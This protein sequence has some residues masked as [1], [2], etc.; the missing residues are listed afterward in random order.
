MEFLEL[1]SAYIVIAIFILII[2]TIATTRS[3][4]P[5]NS[6]K[7]IFPIVFII[8]FVAI[9]THYKITTSRMAEIETL[10]NEGKTVLCENRTKLEYTKSIQINQNSGWILQNHIFSNK[11]YF[12]SFHS[13]RCVKVLKNL[14]VENKIDKE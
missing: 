10:F 6:F 13:A 11:D 1:E 3:F 14:D 12:K 8:L 2:T 7:K 9:F 5:K 4:S